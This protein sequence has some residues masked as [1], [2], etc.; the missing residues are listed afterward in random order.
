MTGVRK[1]AFLTKKWESVEL[2]PQL[3]SVLNAI[4]GESKM[5]TG[6]NKL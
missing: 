4:S 6:T 1:N 5:E 3:L 2:I